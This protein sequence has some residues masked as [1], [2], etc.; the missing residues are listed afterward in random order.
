LAHQ[1]QQQLQ[2]QQQNR[3]SVVTAP[4]HKLRRN[5]QRWTNQ[6][7]LSKRRQLQQLTPT[8][9]PPHRLCLQ[10]LQLQPLLQLYC[11]PY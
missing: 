1:Q 11:L 4:P 3:R 6:L 5:G 2:Q 10:P 9:Q 8:V 7:T